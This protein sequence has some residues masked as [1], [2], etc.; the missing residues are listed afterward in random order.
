MTRAERGRCYG[1][2]RAVI[3]PAWVTAALHVGDARGPVGLCADGEGSR[4]LDYDGRFLC[5]NFDMGETTRVWSSASRSCFWTVWGLYVPVRGRGASSIFKSSLPRSCKRRQVR[6]GLRHSRLQTLRL[7]VSPMRTFCADVICIC[8]AR[9]SDP[10][11][12]LRVMGMNIHAC[13]PTD[14]LAHI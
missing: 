3:P 9:T 7:S 11:D 13:S 2:R 12:L 6:G 10:L 5:Y 14:R 8:G 4:S 1:R